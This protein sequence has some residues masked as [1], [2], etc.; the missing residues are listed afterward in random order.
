MLPAI[1]WERANIPALLRPLILEAQVGSC[2]THDGV[3]EPDLT[4][5]NSIIYIYVFIFIFM[6]HSNFLF[7]CMFSLFCFYIYSVLCL[8]RSFA[9]PGTSIK[10][11]FRGSETK[12]DGQLVETHT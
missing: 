9:R 11:I 12:Q 3:P 4:I 1:E 5:K 8:P 10:R 6:T 7:P 2:Y